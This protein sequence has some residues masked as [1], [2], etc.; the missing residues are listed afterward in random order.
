MT[1]SAMM[2]AEVRPQAVYRSIAASVERRRLGINALARSTQ[3]PR[4]I[5]TTSATDTIVAR[6]VTMPLCG[7]KP[8][9]RWRT[10]S[11][12]HQGPS[13]YATVDHDAT[14]QATTEQATR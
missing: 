13:T 7:L 9:V 2:Y 8:V 10:S 12:A 3:A 6:I 4:T 14:V 1:Q 5:P 11:K